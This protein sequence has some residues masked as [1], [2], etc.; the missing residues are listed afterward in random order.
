MNLPYT[1]QLRAVFSPVPALLLLFLLTSGLLQA[2]QST[3]SPTAQNIS[4]GQVTD[5]SRAGHMLRALPLRFEPQ[6]DGLGM[7]SRSGRSKLQIE[8]GGEVRLT[9]I[10]AHESTN[11]GGDIRLDLEGSDPQAHPEGMDALP[12]H[13]NYFLGNDPTRWRRGVGQF[14]KVKVGDVY[15]GIDLIYYGNG[16]ELEHD[17][18]IAPGGDAAKIR[19]QVQGAAARIDEGSGDLVLNDTRSDRTMLRMSR[20]AAYQTAANGAHTPIAARYQR[21]RDGSFGF[22]LGDYDHTRSLTIDPVLRYES[23]LGGNDIDYVYDMQQGSDGSIYVLLFS[24]STDLPTTTEPPGACPTG[25]GPT[26]SYNSADGSNDQEDFYLAKLDPTGQKL[27]FATYIGGSSNDQP[28]AL[29]L[30]TDGTIYIA[31]QSTSPDFPMVNAYS[32]LASVDTET[33][34]GTLTHLSADGSTILYSTYYGD[35]Q[36]VTSFSLIHAIA[37]AGNGIVYMAG[38]A[39]PDNTSSFAR[40]G[41]SKFRNPIFTSGLDYLA[42]FDTTKTGDASLIWSTPIAPHDIG[43]QNNGWVAALGLD[44]QKNLWIFGNASSTFPRVTANAYQPACADT[45]CADTFLLELNPDGNSVL[46]ATYLGGS[47]NAGGGPGADQAADMTLDASGTIYLAVITGS[48]DYPVK[49]QAISSDPALSSAVTVFGAGGTELLYSSFTQLDLP[50]IAADGH[51]TVALFGA[52]GLTFSAKNDLG[53]TPQEVQSTVQVF[54]VNASG[55]DSLLVSTQLPTAQ[56]SRIHTGLFD[57]YTNVGDLW[58]A[59]RTYGGYSMTTVAPYQATCGSGCNAFDGF[60]T[61]IQLLTLTPSSIS[62]PDT[63]VGSSAAAIT[64]TLSNQTATTI[65]L[66][67]SSLT[68]SADFTKDDSACGGMLQPGG[69]CTITF[70]FT[71][72][73][74][75]PLKSTYAIAD[76]NNQNEPLTIALSGNGT[77]PVP[78][79]QPILTPPALS[80]GN[81][82]VNTSS[83]A[84]T[85]TLKN[86]GNGTLQITGFALLGTNTNSFSQTNSCGASLA[87]GASCSITITC[88]PQT[89]GALSATLSA[90][91]PSPLPPQSVALTC[92]GT[93]AAVP[94]ALLTPASSNFGDVTTGTTSPAQTFTLTNAGSAALPITSVALGGANAPN[95]TVSANN[96]GSSLA[97]S[98]SCTIAITFTP[99]GSGNFSANLS[100]IDSVGTQTSALAGVGSAAAEPQATLTPANADFAS[101]TVGSSSTSQT[102]T[103]SNAGNAAL[104]ITSIRVTGTNSSDFV[105]GSNTCG[106]TLAAG[107][108]C[109]VSIVFKPTITGSESASLTVVDS[110]GTQ[111]ASLTGTGLATGVAADFTLAGNPTSQ[112]GARGT[113]VSFTILLSSADPN[114]PF[115]QLVNLSA[116]GLPAGATVTF[117]PNSV[118]PGVTKAAASTMTVTVPAL[119]AH[120]D[121][122]FHGELML[123]GVSATSL[124]FCFG[125]TGSRRRRSLRLLTLAIF[126]FGA[127]AASL[128]G[129]GS[130]TGFAPPGSTST[131]TVTGTSGTT[132]HSTTLTLAVK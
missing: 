6:A 103:L 95:F 108:S 14:G 16:S 4:Q 83:T 39:S 104:P 61:R 106:T 85:A 43:S 24:N 23:Y 22:V 76:L 110:V 107:T 128:T 62:F 58:V 124:L 93:S 51:G 131:I 50:Q 117:S 75:G 44:P 35:G 59:G 118:V 65:Q 86:N 31:G 96:C 52:D 71:P 64:A 57:Q 54:N 63:A 78:A 17:Y 81:T 116:T 19:L 122:G 15:P 77:G 11:R 68:D 47:I 29:K 49:N 119:T 115:T 87:A 30:D 89:I 66:S 99:S 101:V 37:V 28:L 21:N 26:N 82:M 130:G 67:T 125:I 113:P 7:V 41:G 42:K 20:P 74:D 36:N 69:S 100:V 56:A 102:F 46:Y 121:R 72:Q 94:Q 12:G 90:S 105:A 91:Y 60:L 1:R 40:T 33:Y 3:R 32:T 123:A 111:S 84:Q 18:Q 112:A 132:V 109:T 97:A 70:T 126:A 5:G 2:Q 80:F 8:V 73:S 92:T 114:N 48:V 79:P 34:E 55:A 25:C 88:T 127:V 9:T 38:F 98:K 10:A 53:V 13:T 27:L 129:C 45:Q 120:L